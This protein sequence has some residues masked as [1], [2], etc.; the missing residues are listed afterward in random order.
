MTEPIVF[1]ISRQL[2]NHKHFLS[3]F[4]SNCKEQSLTLRQ[5][6][7]SVAALCLCAVGAVFGGLGMA[8]AY[9]LGLLA[10]HTI[11]AVFK[12]NNFLHN[13]SVQ[14]QLVLL[15]LE[16]AKILTVESKRS[17]LKFKGDFGQLFDAFEVLRLW[18]ILDERNAIRFAKCNRDPYMLAQAFV[19][20]QQCDMLTESWQKI[21]K[22][23][24]NPFALA[25][26]CCDLKSSLGSAA[27]AQEFS[28]GYE[29]MTSDQLSCINNMIYCLKNVEIAI[30]KY[31][32]RFVETLKKQPDVDVKKFSEALKSYSPHI[33][34][35]EIC[36]WLL[37]GL[38]QETL[39]FSIVVEALKKSAFPQAFKDSTAF[40]RMQRRLKGI[41]TSKV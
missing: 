19:R 8:P 23:S 13:C 3:P 36:S 4:N 25:S 27:D 28:K 40:L 1:S 24:K 20:L 14:Q 22:D 11:T 41:K 33:L 38:E 35:Q 15:I 18:N 34:T 31:L 29:S 10:N 17:V 7:A 26:I 9:A 16:K 2:L 6:V 12:K 5:K 21:L 30:P 32:K 39:N 37:Q